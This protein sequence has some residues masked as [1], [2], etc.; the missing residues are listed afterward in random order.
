[1]IVSGATRASSRGARRRRAGTRP[2]LLSRH[3]RAT[4]L[5]GAAATL[6]AVAWA[7]VLL[8]PSPDPSGAPRASES[9]SEIPLTT[10]AARSETVP[11]RAQPA[12]ESMVQLRAVT[13]HGIVPLVGVAV[14]EGGLVATTADGLCGITEHFHDRQQ[15]SQLPGF[16][17]RRRRRF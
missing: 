11:A 1:M 12:G 14:A 16:T 2:P 9:A 3:P 15:R 10:L 6:A 17:R 5:I 4:L 13:N 7:I 8:A